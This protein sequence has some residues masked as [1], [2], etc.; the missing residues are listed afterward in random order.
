MSTHN[1]ALIVEVHRGKRALEQLKA[2]VGHLEANINE[3]MAGI[4]EV[5][6]GPGGAGA[7]AELPVP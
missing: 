2:K 3:L 5:G 1:E 6:K 7:V 4:G